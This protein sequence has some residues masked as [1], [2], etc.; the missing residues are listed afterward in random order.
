MGARKVFKFEGVKF[1]LAFIFLMML[2]LF[3]KMNVSAAGATLA[4]GTC[5]PDATY[6]IDEDGTLTISGTGEIV[7]SWENFKS[8]ITKIVINDGITEISDGCFRDLYS[9]LLYTSRCV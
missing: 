2:L 3:G 1:A 7:G 5:G 8:F 9:C 6:T 4:S